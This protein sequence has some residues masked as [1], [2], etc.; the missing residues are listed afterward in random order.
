MPSNRDTLE[1]RYSRFLQRQGEDWCR[2][3]ASVCRERRRALQR[4]RKLGIVT[5]A[6]LLEQFPGLSQRL[7]HS[8]L[9][10]IAILKIRQAVPVLFAALEE[11]SVRLKCAD[12][13][14]QFCPA[15]ATRFFH[16]IAQRELESNR[17]DSSWLNAAI[18][19]TGY[20]DLGQATELL[21]SIFE[22]GDLPGTIRGDAGDKLGCCE[23]DRR[24][25]LYRRCRD[26]VIR[27]LSEDSIHIQFW[28]MY[29]IASL[30]NVAGSRQ[31]IDR[32]FRSALPRLREIAK[33]DHR[34]AQ[35]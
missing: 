5:V 4:L 3:C 8:A 25:R 15:K 18:H 11:K 31:T 6:D 14:G 24:T 17:P 32:A 9:D 10:L 19:A 12:I 33:H 30:C 35:G 28:S 16:K 7:K 1:Q 20:S 26:A 22:R 2:K 13:L 34:L 29:V 23:F 27:G 21:V